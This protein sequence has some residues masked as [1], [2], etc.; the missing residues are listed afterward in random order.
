MDSGGPGEGCRGSK[1]PG[2]VIW[3]LKVLEGSYELKGSQGGHMGSEGPGRLI[4]I[5]G[6]LEGLY[7]F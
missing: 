1:G 6:V 2:R 5:L 4:W 3:V 7:G